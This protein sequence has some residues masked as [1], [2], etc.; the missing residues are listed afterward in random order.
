MIH[1]KNMALRRFLLE[2]QYFSLRRLI[3]RNY[4]QVSGSSSTHQKE[5]EKKTFEALEQ[6]EACISRLAG[7][8]E[9][10]ILTRININTPAP[11]HLFMQDPGNL[12]VKDLA[13]D[14]SVE[15]HFR[16]RAGCW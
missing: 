6:W 12:L 13:L 7:Y 1:L 4:D 2:C 9:P 3:L 5:K 11:Y 15:N 14:S 16:F 8:G 10:L